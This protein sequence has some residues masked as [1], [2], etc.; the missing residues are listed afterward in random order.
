MK[1]R[2]KFR[3]RIYPLTFRQWLILKI[4]ITFFMWRRPFGYKPTFKHGKVMIGHKLI[5]KHVPMWALSYMV[6]KQII[7]KYT[8]KELNNG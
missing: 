2:E 3:E 7:G 5:H 8:K 4:A 1:F 6:Y